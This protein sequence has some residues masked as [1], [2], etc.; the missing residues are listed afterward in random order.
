MA[1]RDLQYLVR[2]ILYD[3]NITYCRAVQCRAIPVQFPCIAVPCR[4]LSLSLSLSCLL[5]ACLV[6]LE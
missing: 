4:A 3:E 5:V 2:C 6:E 1:C